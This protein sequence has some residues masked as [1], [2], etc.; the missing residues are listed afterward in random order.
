M[1][2]HSF[3]VFYILILMLAY[4]GE[5]LDTSF[6]SQ[7]TLSSPGFIFKPKDESLLF[8]SQTL[9]ESR[10]KCIYSCHSTTRCRIFE[11]DIS[12]GRCRLFEGDL[13]TMDELAVDA[14]YPQSI[15]GYIELDLKWFDAYGQSC[16]ACQQSRYLSCVNDRCQ[17]PSR[18]YFDGSVCRSQKLLGSRCIDSKECRQDL[19]HTCL[20]REQCGRK[21]FRMESNINSIVLSFS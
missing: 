17:C 18:T 16:T 15:V 10:L 4:Q 6:N 1:K 20:P 9:T 19:N 2:L 14:S 8:I 3:Q 13:Q 7:W 5:N 11:Y 21:S 12:S